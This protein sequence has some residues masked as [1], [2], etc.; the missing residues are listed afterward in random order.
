ME[1][2]MLTYKY[3]IEK[4]RLSVIEGPISVFTRILNLQLKPEFHGIE[5]EV[6]LT[7]RPNQ[8]N[9]PGTVHVKNVFDA[10]V[11]MP[12]DERDFGDMYAVLRTEKPIYFTF[13]TETDW[14]ISSAPTVEVKQIIIHTDIEPIGEMEVT[15][16]P[17]AAPKY[18]NLLLE[19]A[20]G[21][22]KP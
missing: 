9:T 5:P 20:K 4:Y 6:V 15:T 22:V 3:Q 10:H 2:I 7:F 13:L 16:S 21:K 14:T 17:L 8:Q 11:V 12:L 1:A 18:R 19:V